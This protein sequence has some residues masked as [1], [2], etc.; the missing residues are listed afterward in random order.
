MV[1]LRP[2]CT[3]H[4]FFF[5]KNGARTKGIINVPQV[6][7]CVHWC[8]TK[9]RLISIGSKLIK[10]VVVVVVIVFVQKK[11]G[12]KKCWSKNNPC[13]KN[14][15]T[16]SIGSKN[17]LDKK[18]VRSQKLWGRKIKVY[19]DIKGPCLREMKTPFPAR[20][21]ILLLTHWE[22]HPVTYVIKFF[23]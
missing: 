17:I 15:W 8:F 22:E 5:V 19:P 21:S 3:S 14:F 13:P 1:T 7:L 4:N 11:L 12:R 6:H 16:K 20:I 18:K 23:K 2:Y 10:V 9:T